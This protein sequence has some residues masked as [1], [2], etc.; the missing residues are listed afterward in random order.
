MAISADG[1]GPKGRPELIVFGG[2]DRDRL[3]A[4]LKAVQRDP[5]A[6][7][8]P[9]LRDLAYSLGLHLDPER[10]Q[11]ALLASDWDELDRKLTY[12]ITRLEDPHCVRLRERSGVYFTDRPFGR[13]GR[14]A[15]LFPG[16]GSQYTAMLKRLWSRFSEVREWFELMDRAFLAQGR[17]PVPTELMFGAGADEADRLWEMDMGTEVVFTS[18][19][20]LYAL[21]CRLGVTPD[22]VLGHS[23]GEYSA[24]LAAEA[25]GAQPP[26]L[27]S[28]ISRLHAVYEAEADRGHIAPGALLA[29]AGVPHEVVG[30]LLEQYRGAVHEAMDNCPHQT[31]LCAPLDD[32]ELLTRRLRD[33]GAIV[34]RLPFDRAYHTPRFEPFCRALVSFFDGLPIRAPRLPLWSAVTAAPFPAEPGEI[35]RLAASQFAR[36]VRFRETIE[37]MYEEGFRIF[38]ESGPRGNLTGFVDDILRGQ[39]HMAL[40]ADVPNRD[41]LTQLL[42]VVGALASEGVAVTLDPLFEGRRVHEIDIEG[43]PASKPTLATG[44]PTIQ[45]S[46]ANRRSTAGSDRRDDEREAAV[47]RYLQTMQG[48]LAAQ[49]EVLEAFLANGSAPT[50][51]PPHLPL[52]GEVIA[53]VPDRELTWRRRLTLDQDA[54]LRDHCLGRGISAQ[55]PS[56]TG[57]PVMPLTMTVELMA[58]AACALCGGRVVARIEDLRARRWITFETGEATLEVAARRTDADPGHPDELRVE[59]RV[60]EA[61]DDDPV[62][63]A[64]VILASHHPQPDGEELPPLLGGAPSRWAG[65]RV[66]EEG[67]FTG[68]AFRGVHSVEQQAELGADATLAAPA[69]DRL[70]AG[71]DPAP[72]LTDPV[73]LDAA[74]QVVG[75]WARERFSQG[76]TIFPVGAQRIELFAGGLPA[77]EPATCRVRVNRVSDGEIVSDIDVRSDD[78]IRLRITGWTDRR[79]SVPPEF[80]EFVMSPGTQLLSAPIGAPTDL[81][82]P[83]IRWTG[84]R[85]S[86]CQ[87]TLPELT[88]F[89][90]LVLAYLV[91][92]R[93]ER[94]T[95]RNL[96]S[97]AT[98]RLEWLLGRLAAKDAVR[99]YM[100]EVEQLELLP[101]DIRISADARGKPV[102]SGAW[103]DALGWAPALS[104]SHSGRTAV[105]ICGSRADSHGLG[106]DLEA[107]ERVTPDLSSIA[108]DEQER[109]QIPELRGPEAMEWAGRLWSAKEAAGKAL[110]LGLEIGSGGLRVEALDSQTGRARLRRRDVEASGT[111]GPVEAR[112]FLEEGYAMATAIVEEN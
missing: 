19:Q 102:V 98:R 8:H 111:D 72:L 89:W 2:E 71:A 33:E 70:L 50:A 108:F 107:I 74:G 46:E 39:P 56:L 37:N 45:L 47:S 32:A 36:R 22:G 30:R 48:F 12:A 6:E 76:F 31:V 4:Q 63:E 61:G 25:I 88:P 105:A 92:D 1:R 94:E 100:L 26:E 80:A 34:Q 10:V 91:L 38:V 90:Q 28:L 104:I 13:D 101:A 7:A 23:T 20:A 44:L 99:V 52:A 57:L 83:A 9:W 49:A 35:S 16:E 51:E 29:V 65:E 5:G 27:V 41:G 62:T 106:I 58:E 85:L 96:G 53:Q 66:Y 60:T 86:A 24:L 11:L 15:I 43:P 54:F 103:S 21:L 17:T 97:N 82:S 93:V 18:N 14:L 77:G 55:D 79:M 40:A 112:T 84:R 3:I 59:V 68:P 75:L 87:A 81:L 109:E 64:R 67:M 95:W 73:V 78:E 110:G 69:A 42:H